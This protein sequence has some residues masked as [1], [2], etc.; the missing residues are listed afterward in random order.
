MA[1]QFIIHLSQTLIDAQSNP[2]T[3]TIYKL[4]QKS[5]VTFNTVKKYIAGDISTPYLTTEVIQLCQ[6]FG[7][8]WHDPAF[9]EV[10]EVSEDEESPGQF[11]SLLTTA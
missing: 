6:Y 11:K 2:E 10:I 4:A 5:G 3:R 7:I 1:K 9:V 8:D